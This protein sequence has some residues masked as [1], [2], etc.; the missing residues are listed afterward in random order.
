MNACNA[1]VPSLGQTA[2]DNSTQNQAG[3]DLNIFNYH[4][5]SQLYIQYSQL[6]KEFEQELRDG[7]ITF[8]EFIEKIQ[9]YTISTDVVGLEAK[10]TEAGFECY[11]DLAK[12]RKESYYKKITESTPSKAT[13]KIHAYVLAKI[14]MLF[15]LHII[16]AVNSGVSKETIA[17]MILEKVIQPVQN[18]LETNNVLNIDYDDLMSMVYF[19]TGNCHIKWR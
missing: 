5:Q 19:L 13:Q 18:I 16:L 8:G 12:Q 11:I 17:D 6:V 9:H 2:G 15:N 14:C 4:N 7:S 1:A 10:L 3:R